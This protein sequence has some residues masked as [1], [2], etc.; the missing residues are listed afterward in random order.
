[1]NAV[2]RRT[3]AALLAAALLAAPA[4]AQEVPP[5]EQLVN[6]Y[7]EAL[8]GRDAV[9]A[10]RTSRTRGTFEMPAAGLAGNLEV[11][12]SSGRMASVVEIPGLG[13]IRSGF[14]GTHG[15]SVDPMMGARLMTGAELEALREQ[16]NPLMAVRDPSLFQ[17]METVRRTEMGGEPCWEVRTVTTGGREVVDCYHVESGLLVSQSSTTDSPM[18]SVQA[19]NHFSEYR[20]FGGVMMPTRMVQETMGMQQV[21]TITSVEFDGI[22]AADVAA[23]AEIHALM[24]H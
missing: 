9:L 24:G 6:R 4:V 5:A 21:M 2:L 15:W 11:V 19:T 17:S 3:P 13:T 20:D 18:G 7:V 12:M 22:D 10:Q 1:M 8:G 16:A 23:P 14:D